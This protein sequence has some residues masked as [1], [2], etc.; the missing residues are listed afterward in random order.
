[1]SLKEEMLSRIKKA[2]KAYYEQDNP[3]MSDVEY[4]L[5]RRN[6]IRHYGETDL[7]Y[8]PGRVSDGFQPFKH[9]EPVASLGKFKQSEDDDKLRKK[10]HA[11]WPVVIEPKLDGLTVVAYPNPDGSCTFVTRGDGNEGETLPNFISMYEGKEVNTSGYPIR[12][13]VFLTTSALDK[14]RAAQIANGEEPAKNARN[15]AAGILRNKE[16]SPYIDKLTYVCYD[17]LGLDV[18]E[19]QKLEIINDKTAFQP[20]YCQPIEKLEN[21]VS[22]IEALYNKY[23]GEND[24]PIDGIVIKSEQD[25]SLEIFGRTGHHPNNAAAWKAKQE[26][27]TTVL[28]SVEWQLG[29]ERLTPVAVVD[30]V[31]IDD[32]TITKASLANI[33]IIRQLGLKIG[34]TVEIQKANEIIPQI[35][36]V[37]IPGKKDIE[38]PKTCP[39][40]NHELEEVNGQLFCRNPE[41]P[42]KIAQQIAYL[43]SKKVLDIDGL[44]IQ[45]ARAIVEKFETK[46]PYMVLNMKASSFMKL[47]GFADK[48]AKTLADNIKKC[49]DNKIDLAHAVAACCVSGIG[50][51]IGNLLMKKF[52][53]VDT[54]YD[55][56]YDYDYDFS[57]IEGIG[58]K[59]NRILHSDSF[60][61]N[62]DTVRFWIPIQEY[63]EEDL[64]KTSTFTDKNFVLTGK[65]PKKRSY[66]EELIVQAGGRVA[67]SVSKNTDYLVIADTNSTS[68][69][70]K[71][72]RD[73]GTKLISSDE[74][75]NMIK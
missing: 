44:S 28:R 29:K 40:C 75:E 8:V 34:A 38:I 21:A 41:C 7:A 25:K 32:T 20:V 53:N 33:N 58:E 54:L 10:I 72:A 62:L 9:S 3:I 57:E 6:Y 16:R 67:G 31:E 12:G 11:L 48:S 66:Y 17:I 13:E 47:P 35:T 50:V 23:I 49:K 19:T 64:G 52:K 4:D 55:Y 68:T 43:G 2:D 74:L 15:I 39:S 73:L 63:V 61:E 18:P 60:I 56:A 42:E 71:K 1:M 24:I 70:A 59:T 51:T 37:I 5:L 65:M 69:K 26:I 22:D 45:T 14:I 36:A 27:H 30:P 46:S